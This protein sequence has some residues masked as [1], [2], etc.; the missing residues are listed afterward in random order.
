MSDP[1]QPSENL[2]VAFAKEKEVDEMI[3]NLPVAFQRY[4]ELLKVDPNYVI[5]VHEPWAAKA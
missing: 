5:N 4:P 3:S 2:R 1:S